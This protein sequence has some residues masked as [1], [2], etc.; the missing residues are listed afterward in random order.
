[1]SE[2]P[3]NE[4]D[5]SQSSSSTMQEQEDFPA[6]MRVVILMINELQFLSTYTAT[7]VQL[8]IFSGNR[9]LGQR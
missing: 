9:L 5:E 7:Q 3:P 1:M 6:L 8:H 4:M 2:A